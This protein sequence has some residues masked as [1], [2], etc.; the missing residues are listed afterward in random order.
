MEIEE[1]LQDRISK[2][3]VK[4]SEYNLL[5]R[6]LLEY[7][8][9]LRDNEINNRLLQDLVYK[10]ASA[11][12]K[13]K[14]LNQELTDKQKRLDEDLA[15][16]AEIQQSLLPQETISAE[17][18][19]TAWRFEPCELMGGDIFNIFPLDADHWGIYVVDV[20]GHG[21][22]AAMITVSVS[23]F[24]QP[25]AGSLL[26]VTPEYLPKNVIIPPAEVFDALEKEFPFERFDN[27]FTIAYMI[28]NT[29]NGNLIYSNAGH[30]HPILLRK[31]GTF[32]LLTTA[33]PILGFGSFE[34]SAGKK[35]RFAE[36]Q[37]QIYPGDKLFVYTDGIVEYMNDNQELYGIE[38]FYKQLQNAREKSVNEIVEDSIKFLMQFG[39]NTKPQDDIT[40][41]GLELLNS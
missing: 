25:F 12:N 32:E 6:Q 33:N 7:W 16:A 4:N 2:L 29:K 40:L 34:Q 31:N 30:P 38:R 20:S 35:D 27:F 3:D 22:P 37:I 11:E 28:I 18:L 26:N 17:K 23:Q 21:V 1:L 39:N 13:L 24:L 5:M 14:R 10:Y 19:E 41:I 15:A 9:N 36:G 8:A